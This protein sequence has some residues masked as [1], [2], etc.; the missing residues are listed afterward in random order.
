MRMKPVENGCFHCGLELVY[1]EKNK[2]QKCLICQQDFQ[3]NVSCPTGHFICDECHSMSASVL[4]HRYCQATKQTNPIEIANTLMKNKCIK[5]HGPEH[6]FLVPAVLI[7]AYY[8]KKNDPVTKKEKLKIVLERSATVPGGYCG[9]HGT[10]GAG[11]G[12]GIFISV[13]T[14]STPLAKKE[15]HLSNLMTSISLSAIAQNGGPRCCKR[16]SYI[17]IIESVK[18]LKAKFSFSLDMPHNIRCRF[19]TSNRQCTTTNCLFY[20]N[21]NITID[22]MAIC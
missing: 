8:N 14:G 5:M 19:S 21:Q 22:N 1:S 2:S 6:H 3:S 10:C 20:N 4:I 18:F 7:S 13:I 9:T 17:S 16:D 15:W 12:S 11:I